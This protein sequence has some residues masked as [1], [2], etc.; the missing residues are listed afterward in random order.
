MMKPRIAPRLL[1]NAP[2]ELQLK[3]AEKDCGKEAEGK[4][5]GECPTRGLSHDVNS[6]I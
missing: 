4:H 5:G 1:S 3:H 6:R 2:G